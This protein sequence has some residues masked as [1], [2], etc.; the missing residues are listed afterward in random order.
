MKRE[1]A[2]L[3]KLYDIFGIP[4]YAAGPGGCA[5]KRPDREGDTLAQDGDA[6]FCESLIS[7]AQ[8]AGFLY[9]IRTILTQKAHL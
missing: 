2:C 7:P 5:F 3:D 9:F 8:A 4:V 6:A 1:F